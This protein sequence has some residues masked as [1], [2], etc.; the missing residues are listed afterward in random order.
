MWN[1]G[2]YI[3]DH[4]SF[5]RYHSISQ[6]MLCVIYS[7]PMFGG[8]ST[9]FYIGYNLPLSDY[10]LEDDNTGAYVLNAT[11]GSPFPQ[12]TIDEIEVRVIL[13]EVYPTI[14]HAAMP[15]CPIISC[16]HS[17]HISYLCF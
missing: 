11:F 7:F 3:I 9:D 4:S 1:H 8:W 16:H 5:E 10:L 17:S 14:P 2:I 13:P 15:L 6:D 12:L